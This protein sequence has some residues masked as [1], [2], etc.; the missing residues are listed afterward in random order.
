MVSEQS[1]SSCWL[2]WIGLGVLL[3]SRAGSDTTGLAED[4]LTIPVLFDFLHFWSLLPAHYY[5]F[6]LLVV[7][8]VCLLP[9]SGGGFGIFLLLGRVTDSVVM[10]ASFSS[11]TK[12]QT[13]KGRLQPK[14]HQRKA[15]I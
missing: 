2:V 9:G 6:C 7:F 12:S 13:P 11:N 8:F 4:A 15:Q 5:R 14:K 10:H 1:S 3:S